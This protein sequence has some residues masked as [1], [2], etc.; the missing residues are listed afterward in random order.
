MTELVKAY[1][2]TVRSGEYKKER[3]AADFSSLKKA[4]AGGSSEAAV[5][6]LK[7]V[8]SKERPYILPYD[9]FGFNRTLSTVPFTC[10]RAP[11]NL[12]PDYGYALKR[13]FDGIL[14]DLAARP[15]NE[16]TLCAAEQ[17]KDFYGICEQYREHALQQGNGCLY[18]A[19]RK[20]P[21]QPPETFYE[22]CLMLK[23][24]IYLLRY[25]GNYHMPLGRFDQYMF[26]FYQAD[27]EKGVPKE[28]LFEIL[29]LFFISLNVDTDLYAGAQ[30]GDNGQSM[31]LGG[32]A[33][34]GEDQ[35]NE[36]S[37]MAICA[38]RELKL[39]DPKLNLRVNKTT[40][41]ERYEFATTLTKCGLGFPQYC[42]D[43]VVVPGLIR[44]GY[45]P[46][47]AAD[48]S[49]AAC[50]EFITSGK[51]NDVVNIRVINF[52]ALMLRTVWEKL[53]DCADFESFKR[54]AFADIKR[55][56]DEHIAIVGKVD[57]LHSPILSVFVADCMEKGKDLADGGARYNNFGILSA[58]MST[59]V[60]SLAAV[61]KA[62]YEDG[63]CT[64]AELLKALDKNFDG[65]DRLRNYLLNCPKWG[66]NDPFVDSLAN[67]FLAAV[68]QSINGRP[69]GHGGIYR[70]GTGSAQGYIVCANETGATPDGRKAYTPFSSSFSPSLTAKVSGPLSVIKSFTGFDLSRLINGGPLTMEVHDSV[71]RNSE[72]IKKTAVLVKAFIDRGGH[73]LQI[74]SVNRD[75][76]I[77]AQAHPEDHKNLI[78]RVW[79]WSGY[80]NE[81]DKEYQDHI[82]A[83]T[84]FGV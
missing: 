80:F 74:N 75:V 55:G 76:L 30:L 25:N 77:D 16:L 31:V 18:R 78:V 27:R 84:E 48:Y 57:F 42:N 45:R 29:E 20:M 10:W 24:V 60:D 56:Y 82:I 22:A 83:R 73:Q 79:G 7:A 19:L 33:L 43:D 5:A 59:A 17:I 11:Q 44:L 15:S 12:T 40:P 72:G 49:I 58:G 35:Y 3:R 71:F 70:G 64:A 61:K 38:S 8:F 2:E 14:A 68:D 26:P 52:P 28:K 53:A 50:W 6:C 54:A 1:L 4:A 21:Q 47:D 63:F 62:V 9:L 41:L 39:I 81:L 69:N 66:N 51:G 13:G 46:E 34:S 65:F 37:E 32:Y 36:L 23:M 67:E